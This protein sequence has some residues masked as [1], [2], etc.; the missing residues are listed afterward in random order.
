M[1]KDYKHLIQSFLAIDKF[2][3]STSYLGG[4]KKSGVIHK[5]YFVI[6]KNLDHLKGV[7]V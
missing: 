4:K 2:W 6:F 5:F 7:G 1:L 3:T